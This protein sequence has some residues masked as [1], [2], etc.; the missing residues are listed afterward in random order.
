M[1]GKKS[2]RNTGVERIEPSSDGI[3]A[4][5]DNDKAKTDRVPGPAQIVPLREHRRKKAA[6][7]SAICNGLTVYGSITSYGEVSVEGTIEGDINCTS[8]I[9]GQTG[10]IKGGVIAD[11]VIV[12]GNVRG[13]IHGQRVMLKSHGHVS[14]D[15]FH[16]TISIEEGARFD[17]MSRRAETSARPAE[18]DDA[19]PEAEQEATSSDARPK[20]A[21]VPV[22]RG[23]E[24]ADGEILTVVE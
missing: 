1:F 18:N 6:G 14:G 20:F 4:T 13:D 12:D 3:A 10:L 8:L 7:P 2:K 16:Q 5:Q 23:H 22:A 11:N 19:E 21:P 17:G 9:V 24:K 15:I